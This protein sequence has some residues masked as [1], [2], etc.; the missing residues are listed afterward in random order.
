MSLGIIEKQIGQS[1]AV[2]LIELPHRS[3]LSQGSSV[4]SILITTLLPNTI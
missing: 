3:I 4:N 2:Y 1:T